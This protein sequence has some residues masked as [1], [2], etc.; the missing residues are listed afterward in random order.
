MSEVGVPLEWE[1]RGELSEFPAWVDR[2]LEIAR[3][4]GHEQ[5]LFSCATDRARSEV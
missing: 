3:E 4:A 5:I 2:A 1:L